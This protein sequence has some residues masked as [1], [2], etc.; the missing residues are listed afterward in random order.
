MAPMVDPQAGQNARDDQSDDRQVAGLPPGP[1][2]STSAAG[3][4]TQAR[5]GAPECRWH[6][7]QE[8]VCGLPGDPAARNRMFPQRQPPSSW[9]GMGALPF[10]QVQDSV[11]E[12]MT[13]PAFVKFA[14]A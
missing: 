9:V 12:K 8:Q 4:S 5:V 7:W 14:I 1:V 13:D 2:H 10:R 3:Y 11:S 6:M